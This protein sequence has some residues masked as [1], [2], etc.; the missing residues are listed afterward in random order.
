MSKPQLCLKWAGTVDETIV[1]M[2]NGAESGC[3]STSLAKANVTQLTNIN[4]AV[5]TTAKSWVI[6]TVSLTTAAGASAGTFQV[7]NALVTTS[8][9]ILASVEYPSTSTGFP[10]IV[11]QDVAAGSFKIEV[12]NQD[13]VA[14]L[15]APVKVHFAIVA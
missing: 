9:V 11:V 7:N 12:R 10:A 8:S 1:L 15:N 13:G 6:T 5:T 2:V 14:A 4:T 3:V